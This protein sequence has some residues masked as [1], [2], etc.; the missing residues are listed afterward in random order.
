MTD[1][2]LCGTY[3]C[4]SKNQIP[5]MSRQRAVVIRNK[6]AELSSFL[7]KNRSC[8]EKMYSGQLY[9]IRRRLTFARF[10]FGRKR[11]T[12]LLM[13]FLRP[14]RKKITASANATVVSPTSTHSFL[15]SGVCM[16]VF[17]S[18]SFMHRPHLGKPDFE[19]TTHKQRDTRKKQVCAISTLRI[20]REGTNP[21][22]RPP[23]GKREFRHAD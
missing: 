16:C 23:H 14:R 12:L 11:A 10:D 20:G 9:W 17:R 13:S 7:L 22:T 6:N 21:R 19:E 3:D 1:R 2:Y 5:R 8:L 18:F 15:A 4:T